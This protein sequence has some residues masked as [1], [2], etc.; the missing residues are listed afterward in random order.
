MAALYSPYQDRGKG[1][2]SRRPHT[3]IRTDRTLGR[4]LWRCL[5][6]RG[7]FAAYTC[8]ILNCVAKFPLFSGE[9]HC[10]NPEARVSRLTGKFD[11]TARRRKRQVANLVLP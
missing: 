6:K 7:D 5:S 2:K 8:C 10:R 1:L 3:V 4:A 9:L 11:T